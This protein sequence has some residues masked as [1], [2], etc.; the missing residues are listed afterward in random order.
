MAQLIKVLPASLTTRVRVLGPHGLLKVFSDLHTYALA[1]MC[2]CVSH[3]KLTHKQ[4]NKR[5]KKMLLLDFGM[6]F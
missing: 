3:T 4:T 5:N 1:C 2:M 6:G